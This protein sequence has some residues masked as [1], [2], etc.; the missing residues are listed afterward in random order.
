MY[1]ENKT[2]IF[3]ILRKKGPPGKPVFQVSVDNDPQDLWGLV[4][5]RAGQIVELSCSASGGNPAPTV[6][7]YRNG[8]SFRQENKVQFIALSIDDGAELSCSAQNAA[9]DQ[10]IESRTVKLNV[11]SK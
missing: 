10:P 9:V 4:S 11:L 1:F 2:L 6:T 7:I 3:C 8:K 5:V